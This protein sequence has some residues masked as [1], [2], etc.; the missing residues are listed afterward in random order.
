MNLLFRDFVKKVLIEDLQSLFDEKDEI[1]GMPKYRYHLFIL[2]G[3]GIETLGAALDDK[4][5][6]VIGKSGN[7]FNNALKKL[8]PLKKYT[9]KD[10][11][12]NY[13]CGMCHIY[14]PNEGVGINSRLEGGKHNEING[15]A[16]LLSIEDLFSDFV[17]AC[18]E[19]IKKI[20]RKDSIIDSKVYKSGYFGF[21]KRVITY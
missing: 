16:L 10:L 18:D 6:F 17:D 12:K 20:D 7:R 9:G 14:L 1:T 21:R 2:I 8:E 11:Y 3:I 13:R 5:W 4:P 15:G 19:I